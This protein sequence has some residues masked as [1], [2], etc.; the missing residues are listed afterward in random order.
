[1]EVVDIPFQKQ[2]VQGGQRQG[3]GPPGPGLGQPEALLTPSPKPLYAA[4]S[5][6]RWAAAASQAEGSGPLYYGGRL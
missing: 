2:G 3:L 6:Q 4:G 5:V 1:M